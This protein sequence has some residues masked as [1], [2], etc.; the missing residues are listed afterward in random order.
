MER[1]EVYHVQKLE[2]SMSL[3]WLF[4]L[5]WP[6]DLSQSQSKFKWTF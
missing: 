5:K 2:D 4:S 6:T 3:R 1:W